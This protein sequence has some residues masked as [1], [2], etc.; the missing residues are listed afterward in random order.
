MFL[1]VFDGLQSL[2][3]HAVEGQLHKNVALLSAETSKFLYRRFRP[4][5]M[6]YRQGSQPLWAA[7]GQEVTADLVTNR[8][9]VLTL[10][11]YVQDICHSPPDDSLSSLRGGTEDQRLASRSRL[12]EFQS[13]LLVPWW[14][15][16]GFPA[17]R[18]VHFVGGHT[19]T[20]VFFESKWTNIDIRD[21]YILK[22]DGPFAWTWE[23]W[24]H[25]G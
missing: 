24:T 22:P 17:R 12:C 16:A 20:E 21:I 1:A 25:S 19:V 5:K 10:L 2:Y 18:V 15:V 7:T 11:R 14:Q 8:Q 6:N 23:I 13:G 9:K 4:T 3:R